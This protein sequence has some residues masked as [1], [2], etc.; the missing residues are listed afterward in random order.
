MLETLQS[1]AAGSWDAALL[2]EVAQINGQLL[3]TLRSLAT[4]RAMQTTPTTQT[5]Q[6]DASSPRPA[7]RLIEAMQPQ[8]QRLDDASLRRLSACEFLLL[9]GGFSQPARWR[10]GASVVVMER[11]ASDSYF[12][13]AAGVA[14]LGRALTL[15]WHM[16]RSNRLM[17]SVVL[18]LNPIVADFLAHKGLRDLEELAE[19][20]PAWMAPRWERQP[21]IWGQM[22]D[23]AC[24]ASPAALDAV[25]TRGWQLLARESLALC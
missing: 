15:A 4:M 3:D 17:A 8:W 16:V 11:G 6:V 2:S 24:T 20:A 19:L 12:R 7:H 10:F 23:A 21:L 18:G 22:I 25:R 1:F 5:T 9:D 13:D 14:L